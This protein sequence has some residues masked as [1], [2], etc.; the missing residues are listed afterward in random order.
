MALISTPQGHV[1]QNW[2]GTQRAVVREVCWPET[3]AQVAAAMRRAGDRG[4]RLKVVG[5]GHSWS[6]AAVPGYQAMSLDRLA[7][8]V[9]VDRASGEV[10]VRG[11]T[12]LFA[13]NELLSREGLAMPVLGSIAQ[14][15]VAG[16]ISTGTHGSAPRLGNLASLVS[17]LRMVL[18]DGEV[19][20]ASA[21]REPDLFRAARVGLGALGVITELTFRC[22]PAF[23]LEEE[24]YSLPFGRALDEL[25]GLL[26]RED[27]FKLWWLPH[28]DRIQVFR[29]RRTGLSSTFRPAARWL[30]ERLVNGLLFS[31]VLAAGD[32]DP[33]LIPSLN[34]AV[35]SL[36]F[37]PSRRVAPSDRCFNIAMPPVHDETEV[38]LPVARAAEA[39]RWLQGFIDD[40]GLAIN[41]VIEARFGAG[42]DAWM[43]PAH[44]RPSCF[45]GA[46][47][48]SR[49]DRDLFFSKFEEKM[50]SFGGRPHWGKAFRAGRDLLRPLYPRFDDFASLRARLDPAGLLLNPFVE[51]VFGV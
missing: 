32:A 36:Y 42:D 25:P 34:R 22:V 49:R 27:Y 45:L 17:R 19:V 12:R 21:D 20:E 39:L 31:A 3:E 28:T 43:S 4:L 29:Y 37:R 1:F 30:D 26:E 51:R 48:A 47:T 15:S 16:A 40:N 11:G 41:F 13:L 33:A 14:Q 6:D 2:A 24:G 44:G 8:L 50:R 18:P 10:T 46:Y 38:A 7:G 23:T 35:S 5:A 9:A